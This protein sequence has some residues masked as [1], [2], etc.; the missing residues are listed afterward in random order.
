VPRAASAAYS[1]NVAA[2]VAT[3]VRD[4]RLALDLEDDVH[5]GIVIT[6]ERRVVH[7]QVRAL[8]EGVPGV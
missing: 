8:L 7:P 1:R 5:A 2:A 3:L 6:H 4:G